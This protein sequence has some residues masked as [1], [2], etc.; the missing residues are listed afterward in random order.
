VVTTTTTNVTTVSVDHKIN[1]GSKMPQYPLGA[2]IRLSAN[3]KTNNV[4]VDPSTVS[5]T[6]K[7]PLG[8]KTTLVYGTDQAVVRDSVGNFYYNYQPA[9]EGAIFIPMGRNGH[10]HRR[11][12]DHV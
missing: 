1:G 9:V 5:I 3:F 10:K 11:K 6:V 8:V 2:V 12:R 4:N 7:T